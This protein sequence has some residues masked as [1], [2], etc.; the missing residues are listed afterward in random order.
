MPRRSVGLIVVALADEAEE[1][2]GLPLPV[3]I[4]GWA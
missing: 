4:S 1:D 3:L 2:M